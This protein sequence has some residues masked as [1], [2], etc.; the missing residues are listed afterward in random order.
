MMQTLQ[1]GKNRGLTLIELSVVLAI[2]GI[3][4]MLLIPSMRGFYNS[5]ISEGAIARLVSTMRYAR[6]QAIT[7]GVIHILSIDQDGY[8]IFSKDGTHYK[9]VGRWISLPDGVSFRE[10][11]RFVFYPSGMVEGPVLYLHEM[12]SHPYKIT[13]NPIGHI[14]V[15]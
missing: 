7:K 4:I 14:S 15:E 9:P 8:Q 13:I 5:L 11:G 12:D 1:T 3:I 2:F 6:S 10:K